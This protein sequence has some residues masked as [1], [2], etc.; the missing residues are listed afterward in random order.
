LGCGSAHAAGEAGF[1]CNR[2]DPSYVDF[3][4]A[5]CQLTLIQLTLFASVRVNWDPIK[6]FVKPV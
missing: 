6:Y 2:H 1:K 3:E 5:S 4:G